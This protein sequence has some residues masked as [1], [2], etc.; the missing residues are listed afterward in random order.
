MGICTIKTKKSG[1]K[2]YWECELR[3]KNTMQIC[4]AKATTSKIEGVLALLSFG[5][6]SHAPNPATQHI[7]KAVTSIKNTARN[8]KNK[9]CQIIQAQRSDAGDL[10]MVVAPLMPSKNAS[11][12]IISRVRRVNKPKEPL[13]IEEIN[14]PERLRLTISG[15]RFLQKDIN[16]GDEKVYVFTTDADMRSLERCTY[17]MADGTFKTAPS[18]FMQL[19]TIHGCVGGENGM[20]LP[21]VYALMTKR[22]SVCYD[23]VMAALVQIAD[24]HNLVLNPKIIITDFEQAEMKSFVREFTC[25]ESKGCL[26]HFGQNIYRRIQTHGLAQRYGC[27]AEFGLN[28]RKLFALA[29]LPAVDIEAAFMELKLTYDETM[30]A[31]LDWFESTYVIGQKRR[32]SQVTRTE[33]KFPPNVWSVYN[34]VLLK[35]PRTQNKVES[36]HNRWQHLVG[37]NPGTYELIEHLRQEEHKVRCDTERVLAGV[38]EPRNKAQVQRDNALLRIVENRANTSTCEYLQ[39]IANHLSF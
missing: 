9:P 25:A 36:W 35:M 32:H 6:H 4:R 26:F 12:K 33:A 24:E 37:S 14:I 38:V 34:S 16:I 15:H 31:V 13:C 18:M 1:E 23:A 11:R 27:D 39:A 8:T 5:P 17:W 7:K 2:I 21:L 28:V 10:A 19:L 30:K 22:T 3:R 20:V 29:F